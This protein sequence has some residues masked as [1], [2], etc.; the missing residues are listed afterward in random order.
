MSSETDKVKGAANVA[1]GKVKK[2]VGK[3]VGNDRLE[4]DGAVQSAKGRVQQA[5]G[6]GKSG[7]KKA[8]DRT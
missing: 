3:T 4:A 2:A 6:E 8:I 5:V 7:L 1:V